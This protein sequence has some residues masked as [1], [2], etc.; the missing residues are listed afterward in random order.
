MEAMAKRIPIQLFRLNFSLNNRMPINADKT[1]APILT[2]GK[3]TEL[4]RS[5][6]FNAFKKKKSEKKFG[7][8]NMIPQKIF[9]I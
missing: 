2:N 6:L 4:L 3:T 9:F 7:I 1:T 8:P 5:G